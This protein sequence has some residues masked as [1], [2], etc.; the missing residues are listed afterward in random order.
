MEGGARNATQKVFSWPNE[1][2]ELSQSA[3][4]I[5]VKISLQLP[6]DHGLNKI[7]IWEKELNGRWVRVFLN[8]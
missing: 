6:A 3:R 1:N 4:V 8:G 2:S 5:I 7:T